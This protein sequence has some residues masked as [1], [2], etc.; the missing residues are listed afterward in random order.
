MKILRHIFPVILSLVFFASCGERDGKV[1]PRGELAEI[2]AE[3]LMMDQWISAT[4]GTRNMADTS[5]V[6]EPILNRYGYTSADYRMTVEKYMD[7]PERFSRILR[8]TVGIFDNKIKDLEVKMQQQKQQE[9]RRKHL[10]ELAKSIHVEI[11]SALLSIMKFHPDSVCMDST[12]FMR[13]A[14]P[15]S[16]KKD[17]LKLKIWRLE[18]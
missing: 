14:R 6:Y 8:T 5:L 9:E 11:D 7:D 12:Y 4:P 10:E 18:E 1:I 16:T 15:D 13:F 2:Y 3:M 17:T